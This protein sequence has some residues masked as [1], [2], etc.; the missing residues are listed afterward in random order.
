MPLCKRL[1]LQG[2]LSPVPVISNRIQYVQHQIVD[3]PTPPHPEFVPPDMASG[4]NHRFKDDADHVHGVHG[5][6][7]A[8]QEVR[9]KLHLIYGVCGIGVAVFG[10]ILFVVGF[11]VY[12]HVT[13]V[14]PVKPNYAVLDPESDTYWT[15]RTRIDI[16]TAKKSQGTD[17]VRQQRL[18]NFVYQTVTEAMNIPTPYARAQAVT[19]IAG[20]L[21]QNDIDLVLDNPLR[22]LGDTPLI[23]S[24]RARVLISQALMYIRQGR[25]AAAGLIVQ[26][27]NKLVTDADLKLNSPINEESFFGIVT[28]LQCLND[29]EG[30]TELFEYQ[31]VSTTTLGIDQRMKA[32]RMIAGEQVR[33]G[34]VTEA[35]ETTKKINSPVELARAWTLLLQYSA[36]PPEIR[37]VEPIMLD[38]LDDPQAK[39]AA[40]LTHA[41]QVALDIF[42]YIAENKD[43]NTQTSLLQR[44]AGSRLMCDAELY[45]LF[46]DCLAESEVIHDRIKQQILNLLDNPESPTI[47]AALNMP[48]RTE[49][50]SRQTDSAKDDW[51]TSNETSNEVILMEVTDI[52]PTPLRTRTDQQ[53]VQALLAVAQGYHSIKRFQDADRILKQAFVA[54][55]RFVDVNARISLLMRIGEQQIAA[56]SLDDA[57]KT[58]AAVAPPLDQN[59]K[60]EL[61]RLQILGRLFDDAFQT[62]ASIESPMNREYACSFLLQEQIRINRLDDAEK[63]WALMPQGRAAAECRNRLNIAQGKATQDDFNT[64]GLVVSGRDDQ[65]RERYCT[66]LIQQGFLF[67]ADQSADKIS[68]EQKRR[69]VLTR[70]AREY[71]SLYQAFNDTNDPNR[72]VRQQLQQTIVSAANRTGQPVT[73][74]TILTELLM[75]Y[76]GQLRTKD[77]Q[78]EGKQLWTQTMD[79]CRN[80]A[81]PDDQTVLFA[82]LIIVKNLLENPN[83]LK[84]TVPLFTSDTNP[85]AFEETNALI[86]EC[87]ERVNVQDNGEQRWSTCT[88]LARALVQ[89]GR[90]SAAQ[91]LLDNVLDIATHASNRKTSI[92]LFLSMI[93]VLSAMNAAD[94][95]PHI[96]RLAINDVDHEFAG[97][98]SKVDVYEWRMRDSEIE[99]IIR[100]QLENGFVDD[101]VESARRLNEPML[102]DRL[103]RTAAYIYLDHGNAERAEWEARRMTVKEIQENVMQN[104][105]SIKR[106]AE[107]RPQQVESTL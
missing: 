60:G 100:S 66:G 57:R 13:Y 97:R 7:S 106:R 18:R 39:P 43:I 73:Q 20:V 103:L 76:T 32:Y 29:E 61:A 37:P 35:W 65:D 74:T 2:L 72:T 98:D 47:R 94:A 9:R 46:R 63:T 19:S 48:A 15:A 22:R 81:K 93:P 67:L 1:A 101:A 75:Y 92:P 34:R 52:D 42:Q 87:L 54:A 36:R 17:Q 53:W 8:E 38:L 27:Y 69:E 11:A 23:V 4:V 30:L 86:K 5:E 79:A 82:Q 3:T 28:V 68:N 95:I 91:G 41:K 102:R 90:T 6:T 89:M 55:Q 49:P 31:K 64:L 85:Q 84:R 16:T 50:S 24:L 14:D 59:Q 45:K 10:V 62:I 40:F 25:N 70:I 99:Q 33:I 107:I 51:T 83:P 78:A 21:A 12:R 44:I 77:N 104:I 71:L 96:Y 26:Q 56:G 58:F 80:I 105:Q 88:Y